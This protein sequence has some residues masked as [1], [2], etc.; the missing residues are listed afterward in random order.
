MGRVNQIKP[1]SIKIIFEDY[2]NP[3]IKPLIKYINSKNC[4]LEL[5]NSRLLQEDVTS[6][7][8]AKNIIFGKGT[9][10]PGILLG[11]KT[12][13]NLYTFELS[14]NFKSKWSLNRFNKIINVIDEKGIYRE[15]ILRNNWNAE[16][17]QLNLMKKYPIEFLKLT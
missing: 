5:N 14:E 12:I 10:I 8:T 1:K 6:V 13:N 17:F 7:L 11:C 15:S 16:A 3:V 2:S 9:F 4:N